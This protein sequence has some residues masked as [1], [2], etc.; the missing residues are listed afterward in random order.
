V[1][2]GF[3]IISEIDGIEIIAVGNSIRD[4]RHLVETYGSGRWRKRMGSATVR[5]AS[6]RVRR[7]ELHWDEAH[8]IGKKDVKI[9]RYLN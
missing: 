1:E 9:K 4:L 8:G 7:A 2:T 5:L 3:E 6:S